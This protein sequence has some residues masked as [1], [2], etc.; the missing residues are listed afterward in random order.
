MKTKQRNTDVIWWDFGI[1]TDIRETK[2]LVVI[3]N[4]DGQECKIS[5]KFFVDVR[6]VKEQAPKLMGKEIQVMTRNTTSGGSWTKEWFTAMEA[7]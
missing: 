3:T 7:S 6:K 5:K 2:G 1:L 4:E